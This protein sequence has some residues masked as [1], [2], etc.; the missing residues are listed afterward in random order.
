[1][2]WQSPLLCLIHGSDDHRLF[3]SFQ[4][5]FDDPAAYYP[6]DG[7]VKRRVVGLAT[8][9]TI[10]IIIIL[11]KNYRTTIKGYSQSAS[12]EPRVVLV[13]TPAEASSFA[14]CGEI[15]RVVRT[16]ARH[17]VH[18]QELAP[19]SRSDIMDRYHVL[20]TP[21]VLVLGADGSLRARFE[22]EA[23]ETLAAVRLEM[24]HMSHQ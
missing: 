6:E 1:M 14:R 10:A 13:A 19:D 4:R 15:I 24:E 11:A 5:I 8:V 2:L 17:G 9:L 7:A 3:Q 20:E 18:V 21:T 23:P 16:A 22:G 12:S